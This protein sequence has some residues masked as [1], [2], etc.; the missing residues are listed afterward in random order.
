MATIT[1]F[2]ALLGHLPVFR[3]LN[4]LEAGEIA[5]LMH[6]E[7]K[8]AGAV[9][10]KEGEAGDAI[11]VLE[12]GVAVASK[13]TAQGDEQELATIEAPSVIGELALIDGAARSATVR[14]KTA[15]Q[16]YR[17]S[18]K[19]FDALRAKFHPGAYKVMRNLALMLCERLRDTNERVSE[20]YA[21]PEASL[22]AMQKRQKELWAKRQAAA[23]Q[24]AP[25]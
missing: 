11:F 15:A 7:Q 2:A 24:G 13:K 6:L 9:L 23:A 8:P 17:I 25:K 20:F 21:N 10:C 22:Q 12:T 1:R 16:V 4:D 3:G 5:A 19:D 14:L 18:V